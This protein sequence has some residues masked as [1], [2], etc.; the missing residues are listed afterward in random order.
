M[1]FIGDTAYL[2]GTVKTDNERERAEL[3]AR[4]VLEVKH[5][6]NGIRVE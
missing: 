2:K 3:F 5:V 4:S 1:T 6:F